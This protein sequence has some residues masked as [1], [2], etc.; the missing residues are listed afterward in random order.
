MEMNLDGGREMTLFN[1][2]QI[3][4]LNLAGPC[5]HGAYSPVGEIDINQVITQEI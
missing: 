4:N 1:S 2:Q 5:L 3:M